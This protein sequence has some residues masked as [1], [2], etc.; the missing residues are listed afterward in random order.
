[1]RSFSA[2]PLLRPLARLLQLQP[3][4]RRLLLVVLDGLLI[5]FSIWLSFALRLANAASPML[6]ESLWL[7][8]AG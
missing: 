7:L 1:M 5:P 4:G 8:P 6:L 3:L 2:M